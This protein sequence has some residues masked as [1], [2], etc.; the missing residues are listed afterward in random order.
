MVKVPASILVCS[1]LVPLIAESSSHQ[2]GSIRMSNPTTMM[3]VADHFLLL[4]RRA[5]IAL[6]TGAKAKASIIP[7]SIMLENG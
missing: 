3:I 1:S 7:H 6:Y 2:L 5:L 4:F